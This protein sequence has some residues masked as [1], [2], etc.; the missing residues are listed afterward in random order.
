MV[1]PIKCDICNTEFPTKERLER[2]KMVHRK[3]QKSD[4]DPN[5]ANFPSLI[6]P[7]GVIGHLTGWAL[8]KHKKE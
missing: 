6:N 4:I 2:H 1:K 7:E 5:N 8:G 3:K